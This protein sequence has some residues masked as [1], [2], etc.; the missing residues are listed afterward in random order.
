MS[1]TYISKETQEKKFQELAK[2]ANDLG[3]FLEYDTQLEPN[4][5]SSLWNYGYIASLKI[6]ECISIRLDVI[7]DVA[8]YI[9]NEKF[10]DK[11]NSGRVGR[12][13][14][15]IYNSD[16]QLYDAIN[17]GFVELIDNNWYEICVYYKGRFIDL[18]WV[19]EDDDYLLAI[20]EMI[21]KSSEI[22]EYV[23]EE[24]EE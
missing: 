22:L 9:E 19:T 8:V 17:S 3:Y 15:R 1:N 5:R 14:S 16:A 10:E 11:S 24:I 21:D 6:N 2:K 4:Q 13:L 23:K 7:G 12:E 18:M 20:K